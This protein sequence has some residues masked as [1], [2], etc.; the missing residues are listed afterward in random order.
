MVASFFS[1][2]RLKTLVLLS[3]SSPNI[4][5]RLLFTLIISTLSKFSW[6]KQFIWPV[7]IS[8]VNIFPLYVEDSNVVLSTKNISHPNSRV[9]FP[10][11]ILLPESKL[12]ISIKLLLFFTAAILL[13]SE[14][15]TVSGFFIVLSFLQKIKSLPLLLCRVVSKCK[16]TKYSPS[17]ET[18][19]RNDSNLNLLMV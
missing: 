19:K 1:M 15:Q 8:T 4:R 13:S 9:P 10:L 17:G 16:L 3:R 6:P 2:D 14:K 7:V 5:Y 12:N 18:N 11:K